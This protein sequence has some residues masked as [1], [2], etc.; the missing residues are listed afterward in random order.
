MGSYVLLAPESYG[1]RVRLT[2][3]RGYR[4]LV[5]PTPPFG[6]AVKAIF[7]CGLMTCSSKMLTRALGRKIVLSVFGPPKQGLQ[8]RL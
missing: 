7:L 1:F 6:L 5:P 4:I 3:A 8:F 2:A